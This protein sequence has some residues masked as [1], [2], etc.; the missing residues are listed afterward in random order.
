MTRNKFS[1]P[2]TTNEG[3]SFLEVDVSGD[4]MVCYA[5]NLDPNV[6]GHV[7]IIALVRKNEHV[8]EQK[9]DIDPE[10]ATFVETDL[11]ALY[12]IAGIELSGMRRLA[13]ITPDLSELSYDASPLSCL[14]PT[15]FL[16][17]WV[18]AYFCLRRN[19]CRPC[20]RAPRARAISLNAAE[21]MV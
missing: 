13:Q 5:E 3:M 12:K 4:D 15:L 14:A 2:I 11:V 7:E 9:F 18:L 17:A 8:V 16:G 10:I 1:I 21:H 6:D 19:K 20:S